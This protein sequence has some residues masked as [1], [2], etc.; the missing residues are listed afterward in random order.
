MTDPEFFNQPFWQQI[1][2]TLV[3][4]AIGGFLAFVC[5]LYL[6][7]REVQDQALRQDD[8]LRARRTKLLDLLKRWATRT[9][10]TLTTLSTPLGSD[11]PMMRMDT[12]TLDWIL[13]QESATHL[14]NENLSEKVAELR[15][16]LTVINRQIDLLSTLVISSGNRLTHVGGE[17]VFANHRNTLSTAILENASL[18]IPL[19]DRVLEL[20]N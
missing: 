5:G 2:A 10:T 7:Q 16:G 14:G 18:G 12:G 13:L 11:V 8:Q 20:L 6:Y 3:G 17:S 19:C 15:Y 4:T 9:K 1:V